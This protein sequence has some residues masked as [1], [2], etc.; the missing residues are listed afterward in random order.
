MI[1]IEPV[2]SRENVPV[3]GERGAHYMLVKL[4]P[5]VGEEAPSLPL[6]VSSYLIPSPFQLR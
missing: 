3:T 6:N 5:T 4:S 1:R 2:L